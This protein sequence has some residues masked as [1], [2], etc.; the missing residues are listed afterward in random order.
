M[1]VGYMFEIYQ[2]V[3]M[4]CETLLHVKSVD[5]VGA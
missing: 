5:S 1:R 4:V 2:I 3:S